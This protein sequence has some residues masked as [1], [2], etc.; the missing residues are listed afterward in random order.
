MET[1]WNLPKKFITSGFSQVAGKN[2][3]VQKVIIFLDI[4]N[5]QI[6]NA[7]KTIPFK[8]APKHVIY[9]VLNQTKNIPDFMLKV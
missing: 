9:L 4:S 5:K 2:V 3:I 8:I 1:L 7:I 6:E